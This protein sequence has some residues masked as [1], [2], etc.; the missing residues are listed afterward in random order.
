MSHELPTFEYNQIV[1]GIYIGTNQCCRMHFDEMLR[2]EGIVSDISL[3]DDRLDMPFGVE[4][5]IWL[6][7]KNHT[8]PS[9]DNL[10]FG[11]G[12]I[13]LLVALQKKVYVHCKNGHGRAPT[14][15]AAYLIRKGHSPT[16]AES[17]IRSKRPTIHL[18]D[19]Q[20]KVLQEFADR[21]VDLS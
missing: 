13:E 3:E 2:R 10:S 14:L 5:Y 9:L 7:T 21:S 8:A 1:D 15:I 17:L 11:V 19:V 18:E 12:S 6:P 16:E 4:S 20:R